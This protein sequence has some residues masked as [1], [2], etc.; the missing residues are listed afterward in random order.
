MSETTFN[1]KPGALVQC[2]KS[3]KIGFIMR[4]LLS[5][6]SLTCQ[7]SWGDGSIEQVSHLD[8]DILD[9]VASISK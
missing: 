6:S 5:E 8:I 1:L 7:V 9:N 4:T 2:L 3:G